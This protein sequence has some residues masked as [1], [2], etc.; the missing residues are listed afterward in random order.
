MADGRWQ[1]GY[2]HCLLSGLWQFATCYRL[3]AI[4]D[5]LSANSP[6]II[7]PVSVNWQRAVLARVNHI[8]L[9]P[10]L[11]LLLSL[12]AVAPLTYPGLFQSHTGYSAVYNLIDL[13]DHLGSLGTWTPTWGQPF[14]FFRSDGPFGYW[15]AEILH[16]VGF[17]FLDAVKAVYTLAF[18]GSAYGMFVLAGRLF[19]SE[20]AALLASVV[21]VYFPFHIAAVLVRGAFGEAVAW[22]LFPFA[23]LALMELHAQIGKTWRTFLQA[24]IAIG[25]VVL[26]QPGLGILFAIIARIWLWAAP[27]RTPNHNPSPV[28]RGSVRVG[29]AILLGLALGVGLLLPPLSKQSQLVNPNRFTPAFVY[30]F[31]LLT[32]AWGTDPIGTP[33]TS[34]APS[35]QFPYQ[36]GVAALG[37]T[38]LALAL[39]FNPSTR[40]RANDSARRV[41]LAAVAVSALL[42]V[43]LMPFAAPLWAISGLNELVEYPAQLL[44][45]IGLLLALAAG[46]LIVSDPRL[47]ELPLLAALTVVP[48][49]AIYSYLAPEF[50][51]L[52]PTRPALARFNNDEIALLNAQV[53]RPPGVWRHGATVE[54]QLTWQALRQPNRDY[55]VFMHIQDD[56]GGSYG[57]DDSKP[58][59]GALPTLKW[60]PG[61]VIS[62]T[63]S[64]KILLFGPPEGYHLQLGLYQTTTG[65]RAVTETG[66]TEIR[67]EENK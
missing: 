42:V 35:D 48:I 10:I 34:G 18:F 14:D 5:L 56:Q 43:L 30:P 25:L 67:I 2:A 32:A 57:E 28:Q 9:Y 23:L 49:L 64:V 58:Q 7:A 65:D 50:V 29:V 21:Y 52:N 17:P 22:A 36:I 62:D 60:T 45:F 38:I 53:I 27:V 13:H 46:S 66:A 19:R 51:D 33:S 11:A 41:A 1:T 40:G 4:R 24:A 26:A 20:A 31:Q 54:L 12:F 3:F 8:S 37:L 15:L 55:T 6:S 16:L 44:V 63:R 61:Q 39:W 47:A 59:G